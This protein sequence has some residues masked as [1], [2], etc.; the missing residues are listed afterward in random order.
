MT[1]LGK[2]FHAGVALEGPISRQGPYRW[3]AHPA[4]LGLLLILYGMMVLM[5]SSK[6]AWVVTVGVW[7]LLGWRAFRERGSSRLRKSPVGCPRR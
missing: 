2:R 4:Y 1:V 3:I 6:G 5:R 7:P